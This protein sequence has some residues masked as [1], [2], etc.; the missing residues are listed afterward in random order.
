MSEI[1]L[2]KKKIIEENHYDSLLKIK[3]INIIELL[4]SSNLLLLF[5]L[6]YN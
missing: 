2:K 3:I 4:H 6:K 1:F 5:I